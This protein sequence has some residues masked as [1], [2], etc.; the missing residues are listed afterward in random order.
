MALPSKCERRNAPQ[1]ASTPTVPGVLTSQNTKE[2]A[3]NATIEHGHLV[4]RLPLTEPRPS[5][6]GKV[7]IVAS[8]NGTKAM[9][10]EYEG[11]RIIGT[12]AFWVKPKGGRDVD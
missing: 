2:R 1:G 8:T 5:S 10:V 7:L 4:L 3:M 11:R 6:T 9:G 12:A